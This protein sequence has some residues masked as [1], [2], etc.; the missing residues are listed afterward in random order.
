MCKATSIPPF[1]SAL[2]KIERAYSQASDF[3]KQVRLFFGS[4]DKP[5]YSCV[6]ERDADPRKWRAIFRI[7]KKP[8]D[9]WPVLLG[10]II[11]N[12]RSALDHLVY[13]ASAPDKDGFPLKRTEFPIYL[14][15]AKFRQSG[16]QK[17]RGLNDATRA[18]VEQYQPFA[19]SDPSITTY[20]WV[21]QQ[22]SNTD[23]HRLLNPTPVAQV[24]ACAQ[25]SYESGGTPLFADHVIVRFGTVNRAWL[26]HG[27]E[28][29]SFWTK[30]PLPP[31][32]KVNMDTDLAISILFGDATPVASGNPVSNVLQGIGKMVG[33]FRNEFIAR[34]PG[35]S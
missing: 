9:V 21:L 8:P 22:L 4:S 31:D 28:Y 23:K 26:E 14:D 1:Y 34:N 29:F 11:H 20:L 19:N 12:L 3:E 2:L 32:V 25:A 15:E 18:L 35:P 30:E 24:L 16:L 6:I 7:L 27:T 5:A 10:E 33:C 17:I 13:E